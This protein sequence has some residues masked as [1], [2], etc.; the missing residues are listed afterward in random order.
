MAW[1]SSMTA[2]SMALVSQEVGF[3]VRRERVVRR[4]V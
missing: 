3:K 1:R 4:E 2:D